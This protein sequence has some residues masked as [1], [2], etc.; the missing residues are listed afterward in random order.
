MTSI[1]KNAI[2]PR[3]TT[4]LFTDLSI[5]M[6]GL[7]FLT[8]MSFPIL[9]LGL[10]FKAEQVLTPAFWTATLSAGILVGALNYILA[11]RVVRPRLRLLA[12]H[13]HIV[14]S[15]IRGA[16]YSGDWSGCE[17][18][19]CRVPV[20][21]DDEIG[22]SA[23]AFN[24]LVIALFRARE[25]EAAVSDISKA[26][27]SQLDLE[28][29]SKQ[30][31]EL[32]LRH[33][34]T[35]AGVVLVERD[36]TLQ[37]AAQHGVAQAEQLGNSDHVSRAMRTGKIQRVEC[38]EE[39]TIE[40][41]LTYFRPQ[42]IMVVPI[43]FKET[44][45]AVVIL[46]HSKQFSPEVLWLVKLFRQG[47]GLALNNALAHAN[48]QHIAA[49]DA[50]TGAYNRRF[51]MTRLNEEFNRSQRN[52]T[53]LSIIMMDID[54]F[55][56]INDNYGHLIGDRVLSH[57]GKLVRQVL[58]G[59]DVMVRY[60][61]E[62]FLCI[63][64]DVAQDNACVIAERLRRLIASTQVQD[65]DNRIRFTASFGVSACTVPPIGVEELLKRADNALYRAKQ[66]R[67]QV[68]HHNTA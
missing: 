64:P 38:P 9:I 52:Q 59:E 37:V 39:V 13:M 56:S 19:K 65:T 12:M 50:L 58:R 48:L 33:T 20:D 3:I 21:S 2:M 28:I 51:G 45:L 63:L 53:P 8:G 22:D 35:P 66:G 34:S 41:V 10:G 17:P 15:T 60:G 1:R 36:S 31:L 4:K 47:F 61:G 11:L 44:P 26:L 62:E 54:H 67:N 25:L 30:A 32:L 46:A 57:I 16:T 18:E 6:I 42:E 14:E 68:A 43:Q 29:L 55:K 7:G 24:D 40:A 49:I 27:S 23:R 5:W